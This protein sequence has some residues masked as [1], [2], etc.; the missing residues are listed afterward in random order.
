MYK[1]ICISVLLREK[2]THIPE[3]AYLRIEDV[4]YYTKY[5]IDNIQQFKR[6]IEK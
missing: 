6:L 1:Y 3:E 5:S 4:K 2:V